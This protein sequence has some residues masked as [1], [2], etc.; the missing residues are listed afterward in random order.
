MAN[1]LDDVMPK[2]LARGLLTLRKRLAMARLVNTDYRADAAER[3][4]IIH[5][6]FPPKVAVR[7][8][9]P[10]AVPVAAP[11]IIEKTV[12]IALNFW[13]EAPIHFTDKQRLDTI[14]DAVNMAVDSAINSLAESVNASIF[15]EFHEVFRFTGTAGTTPF[16]SDTVAATQARKFLNIEAAP[17]PDRR[18]VIDPEAEAKAIELVKF[19]DSSFRGDSQGIIEGD[20]GRKLGFDWVMDQ[21]VPTH[22]STALSAGAATVNG[23]HAIGA[24]STDNGRTGTVSIAKATNPSNLVRGDLLTIAGQPTTYAVLADVT[25]AVG[26]TTVSITPALRAATVGA[27]VVTLTATHVVNLAFHRAAFALAVRPLGQPQAPGS[28]VMTMVDP[29]S[30]LPLRLEV[31]RQ[32]KQDMWSFDILWGTK[33]VRNELA[34]R[35]LG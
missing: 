6:P 18:V 24:G 28:A 27:E 31:S 16:A 3:G 10:G 30:G 23:V 34:C 17:L 2:I 21:Q 12:P 5:V 9:V 25:L 32:Y 15:A 4:Q 1:T 7:D 33:L 8:V 14:D 11:D 13:K 19:A 29:L 26:N 35:I 22:T 20:I